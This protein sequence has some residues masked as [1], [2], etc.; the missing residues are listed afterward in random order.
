MCVNLGILR[1]AFH[2]KCDLNTHTKKKKKKKK[3]AIQ[4]PQDVSKEVV[5]KSGRFWRT[6]GLGV[7]GQGSRVRVRVKG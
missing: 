4:A 1:T 5:S 3:Q 2:E 7:K 6:L